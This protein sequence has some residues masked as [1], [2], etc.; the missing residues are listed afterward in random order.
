MR[1]TIGCPPPGVRRS[2]TA[3]PPGGLVELPPG[4]M[5]LATVKND[6]ANGMV[7]TNLCAETRMAYPARGDHAHARTRPGQLNR[8]QPGLR[9]GHAPPGP[10]AMSTLAR[11][12]PGRQP[13][14]ELLNPPQG[15][16]VVPAVAPDVADA[17]SEK[18]PCH[19]AGPSIYTVPPCHM[20]V[21]PRRRAMPTLHLA[22]VLRGH[23]PPASDGAAHGHRRFNT[24]VFER[25]YHR[26]SL[27]LLC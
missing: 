10:A 4:R 9:H 21:P 12:P 14:G 20:R 15:L 11:A 24:H 3:P 13:D 5:T 23:E 8:R 16:L 17:S 26:R 7:S 19:H 22:N 6:T 18:L 2:L 27:S 1:I 25:G